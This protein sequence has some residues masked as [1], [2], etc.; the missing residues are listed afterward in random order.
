MRTR[1]LQLKDKQ[2]SSTEI[3][4]Y[5]SPNSFYHQ[6]ARF[7]AL[8]MCFGVTPLRMRWYR[9][10]DWPLKT[11]FNVFFLLL[12]F[13]FD[14][15]NCF[16]VY[17]FCFS[18]PRALTTTK[19]RIRSESG[20]QKKKSCSVSIFASNDFRLLEFSCDRRV[21]DGKS[22]SRLFNLFRCENRKNLRF[23][24]RFLQKSVQ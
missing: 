1:N 16:F 8:R 11:E 18:S 10:F 21:H 13:Y 19:I 24:F 15:M 17:L 2:I 23:F 4:S 6:I 14:K 7:R 3:R 9:C 20:P 5:N 12:F 22:T